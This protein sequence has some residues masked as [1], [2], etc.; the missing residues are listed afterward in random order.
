MKIGILETGKVNP[1]LVEQHGPY[2]PMFRDF[3]HLADDSI[4]TEAWDIVDKNAIPTSPH[5]ADAWIITGSAHGVYD[6]L[7]WIDPLK[8][9]LQQAHSAGVPLVG[10]CFGHQI[11]AEA[12]GGKVV[13]SDKGWGCGVHTYQLNGDEPWMDGAEKSVKVHAMHQDQVVELPP[14]ARVIASSEFCEY[15]G[16]AYG[17]TALSMQPH[18][19]FN[20]GYEGDIIR[21]RRADAIPADVA[22]QGLDSL[23]QGVDNKRVSHWI[24]DFLRQALA[25]RKAA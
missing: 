24:V 1:K 10:I 15:A 3:L 25:N 8:G 16:L 5:D 18:P 14:G 21:M 2:E 11:L 7:P 12:L 22:D 4:E 19:E 20:E 6:P 9:F 13:K 17:D 23:S